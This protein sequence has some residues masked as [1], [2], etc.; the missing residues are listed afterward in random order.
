M[1]INEFMVQSKFIKEDPEKV[2]KAVYT[3][4]KK[5]PLFSAEDIYGWISRVCP[6]ASLSFVEN[7]L[8]K[9]FTMEE[10]TIK[11]LRSVEHMYP[12]NG[13]DSNDL[14]REIQNIWKLYEGIPS[15][16]FVC[17]LDGRGKRIDRTCWRK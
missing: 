5:K 16:L 3:A 11:F 2:K 12:E 1:D 6:F 8:D 9:T 7:C 17:G 14:S 15:R 13:I 4:L 10:F